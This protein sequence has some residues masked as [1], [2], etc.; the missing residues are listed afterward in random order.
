MDLLNMTIQKFLVI[1]INL[2]IIEITQN[3]PSLPSLI[4]TKSN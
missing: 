4:N 3:G 1:N 2:L